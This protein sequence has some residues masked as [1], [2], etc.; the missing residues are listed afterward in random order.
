MS[1]KKTP[2]RSE[3]VRQRRRTQAKQ[4]AR[5][6]K[7]QSRGKRKNGNRELPPIT[8]RGVVNEFAVERRKKSGK[9][10]FNAAI[11]MSRPKTRALSMPRIQIR[12]GWRLLSFLLVLFFGAGLY[13]FWTH[14]QFR[15]SSAHVIGNQRI[16]A[17][18]INSV[19]ELNGHPI[20]LLKPDFIREQA[21]RNYPELAS[22]EVTVS[23]PNI[24]TVN[25]TE[26]EPIILWQQ[27]SGY[28]WVDE[29]G[30]AFHPRGE[31]QG[32]IIVQAQ[33]ELLSL[34]N[35]EEDSLTPPSFIPEETVKAIVS[36]APYVP[37]G[38]VIM[39]DPEIGL[40]W[41][42]GRGWQAIFGISGHDVEVKI[43]VYKT[44]VDWLSQR[45]TQPLIIN[46]AYPKAPYYRM[47][48]VEVRAEEQ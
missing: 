5:S 48:Q 30:T 9:R 28:T 17:D 25:V 47:E 1:E 10:R 26:R 40:S 14:P 44:I 31:A 41:A 43:L 27:E 8:T 24:V 16:S 20:F 46:V 3:I 33:G 29:T 38:S 21:L 4:L 45:S 23:L 12:I 35:P 37:S 22:V 11:S 42:D 7:K 34:T 6:Q 32:L 15:V 13:L 19:L 2:S 18:E 39:Y 36:L